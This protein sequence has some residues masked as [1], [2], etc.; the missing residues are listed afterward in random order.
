MS[1][2][3]PNN[4]PNS[5]EVEVVSGE[6]QLEIPTSTT[7][8]GTVNPEQK[9]VDLP[10][11]TSSSTDDAITQTLTDIGYQQTTDTGDTIALE[12]QQIP[13]DDTSVPAGDEVFIGKVKQIIADDADK[14]FLE[15]EAS[16]ELQ[17]QYLKQRFGVDVEVDKEGEK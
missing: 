6:N 5:E 12:S 3:L 9:T 13:L 2:N 16:E 8:M 7:E 1:Q 14:P 10:T 11:T 17:Q 4:M 15:E